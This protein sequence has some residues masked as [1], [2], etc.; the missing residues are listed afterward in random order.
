MFKNMQDID[1]SAYGM[2]MEKTAVRS[3]PSGVK[4]ELE[5]SLPMAS[6]GLDSTDAFKDLE[7][8]FLDLKLLNSMRNN[9]SSAVQNHYEEL[10][11]L[12]A[13]SNS[14]TDK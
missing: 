13:L 9:V 8:F 7:R 11:V 10:L 6:K 2:Y 3:D 14:N 12:L 5:I 1:L 4:I